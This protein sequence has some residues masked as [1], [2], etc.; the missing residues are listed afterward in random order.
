VDAV[1]DHLEAEALDGGYEA[2]DAAADRLAGTY[3]SVARLIGAGPSEI[4]IVQN[5]TRAWDA[6]C[7]GIDFRPGDRVLTTTSEYGSNAIALLHLARSRGVTVEVVPDDE[8]GQVSLDALSETLDSDVRLVAINF[9]PTHDGLVNPVAEVGRLLRDWPALYM[10]DAV[11]AVGQLPVDVSAIGCDLLSG[12]GRKFL[13]GPRGMGF[14]Y[15]RREAMAQVAP[16]YLDDRSAEWTG[17]SSYDVHPDARRYES[18]ERSAALQLGLGAAVDYAL[19]LGLPAIES[20]VGHLADLLRTSLASVPGVTVCDRGARLSG[21]VT[22]TLAG[23]AAADVVTDLARLRINVR[24]SEQSYR[25]DG[26]VAPEP[27]VR[28]SVHYYNTEEEIGRLV[29][30]LR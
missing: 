8:R 20:R 27:R 13:R 3:A 1:R 22:F 10:V 2:A 7:Y 25:F 4:A 5:A 26:G 12:T 9:V 11:Q 6:A 30:A 21:I 17:P 28:A 14:L 23:R 18:Y 24:L 16:T 19:D 29:D 15:V